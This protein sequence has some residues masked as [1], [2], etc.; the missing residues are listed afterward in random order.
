VTDNEN[1]IDSDTTFVTVYSNEPPAAFIDSISPNPVDDGISVSFVGH[2]EDSDGSI[3][4][5]SWDSSRD[6]LL[7]TGSSFS[8]SSLSVGTHTIYFKVKDDDGDWSDEVSESLIV[9]S[10]GNNNPPNKPFKLVGPT[11]GNAGNSYTY[12]SVT[13]DSD[14]DQIYYLF[15]W[16]DGS[17]SGWVGP[18]DSGQIVTTSH[19]W[20]SQGSYQIKVKAKDVHNAESEWSDPLAIS[21]PKD[22]TINFNSLFLNFLENHPRMFPM[23]RQLLDRICRE[24]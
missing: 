13:I 7:S 3:T 8:S 17:N 15:E 19:K 2:G 24:L 9:K 12:S 6:G 20:D 16:G 21:I 11:S 18:C 5:Y 10:S 14:G 4:G 22:K 23:L 1:N